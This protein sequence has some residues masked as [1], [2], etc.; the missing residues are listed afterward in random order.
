MTCSSG[1]EA[2]IAGCT[3]QTTISMV[4]RCCCRCRCY[5][6]CLS[7]LLHLVREVWT[8]QASLLSFELSV[9][10]EVQEKEEEGE[11][12]EGEIEVESERGE[13]KERRT[14]TWMTWRDSEL[15][16]WGACDPTSKVWR[17]LRALS[18]CSGVVHFARVHVRVIVLVVDV[19]CLMLV[20][21]ALVVLL[22]V[23]IQFP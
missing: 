12:G 19:V 16:P 18:A 6:W 20:L 10:L 9:L 7:S 23:C 21:S 22:A 3:G 8:S 13:L 4:T 11:E 15:E 14:C 2:P 17:R 1:N 5:S